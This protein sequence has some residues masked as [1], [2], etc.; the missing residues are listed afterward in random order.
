MKYSKLLIFILT[1][2]LCIFSLPVL[3]TKPLPSAE[4]D[5]NVFT[6]IIPM[7]NENFEIKAKEIKI[8]L[9]AD[10]DLDVTKYAEKKALVTLKYEINNPGEENSLTYFLPFVSRLHYIKEPLLVKVNN[11]QITSELLYHDM[12]LDR[13]YDYQKYIDYN[14]YHLDYDFQSDL[15]GYLYTITS[16]ETE[17]EEDYTET[18]FTLDIFSSDITLIDFQSYWNESDKIKTYGKIYASKEVDYFFGSEDLEIE[19][20]TM[21]MKKVKY[22]YESYGDLTEPAT[23]TKT[24]IKIS[25]YFELINYGKYDGPYEATYQSLFFKAYDDEVTLT[26]RVLTHSLNYLSIFRYHQFAYKFDLALASSSKNTLEITYIT[27]IYCQSKDFNLNFPYPWENIIINYNDKLITSSVPYTKNKSI[28]TIQTS[29]SDVNIV[30]DH[31]DK[32]TNFYAIMLTIYFAIIIGI[33]ALVIFLLF[34]IINK[35]LGKR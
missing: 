32:P 1:L 10:L 30:F 14:D 33:A 8:D 23:I 27:P 2:F 34:R 26:T 17:S 3:A 31:D 25:D 4:I 6:G 5:K 9:L 15:D 35:L 12:E 20:Q 19:V 18:S 11:N 29:D 28:Y 21:K 13:D 22:G 7:A 16:P 24:P